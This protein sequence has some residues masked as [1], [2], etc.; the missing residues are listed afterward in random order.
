MDKDSEEELRAALAAL[1]TEHRGLDGRIVALE[2]AMTA[3]QLEL[4]RLKKRKLSLRDEIQR[5]EDRLF[6]DIIA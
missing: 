5:I 6:P 4:R 1:I 3:D 2:E